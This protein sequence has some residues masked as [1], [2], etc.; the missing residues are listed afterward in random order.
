MNAACFRDLDDELFGLGGRYIRPER[1][2][3]LHYKNYKVALSGA[4][5]PPFEFLQGVEKGSEIASKAGV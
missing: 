4:R 2:S 1:L 3:R 5:R